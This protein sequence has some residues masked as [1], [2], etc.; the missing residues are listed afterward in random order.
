VLNKAVEWNR[1]PF[2]PAARIKK[3]SPRRK[4]INTL[5]PEQVEALRR[6]MPTEADRRLVSLLAY[7]GLRPGEALA[8]TGADIGKQSISVTKALALGQ[9]KATKTG[10]NRVVPLLK[11][12]A[13]DLKGCGPGLLFPR[14]DGEPWKD[15]DWRNWRRRVWRPAAAALGIGEL[16]VTGHGRSKRSSYQGAVPYVLRHSFASL[17]FAE[18]RNPIEISEMMGNRPKV[19]L[20]TY[21]HVIAELRGEP[22]QSAEERIMD[23]RR[24]L[25]CVKNVSKAN[26]G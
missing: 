10:R 3:P 6:A 11:P 26:H 5:S 24:A 25:T 1:I 16:H 14:A 19:L 21:A 23:A 9:E 18:G 7:S 2:N 17:M 8:L 13:D 22:Q 12:L 15:H 4:A 20:D